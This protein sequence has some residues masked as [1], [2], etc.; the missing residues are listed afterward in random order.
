MKKLNELY[1]GYPNIEIK[2]IKTNSKEITEG[3]LFVCTMG[4]SVDRHDFVDDAISK[5]AVAIV[6]SKPINVSVPVIMVDNTNTELPILVNKFYD[7]PSSKMKMIG[8]TGTDGK[9]SITTIL[10]QM[11]NRV[12]VSG[13]IGT[14]GVKSPNYTDDSA[15]TTPDNNHIMKYLNNFVQDNCKYACLE[16]SSEGLIMR[17]VDNI[18]FDISIFTNLTHEHLNRH[19][20]MDN[21]CDAKALLFKQTNKDGISIINIDDEY[22]Q[23]M[24]EA[25][26]SKVSTY[27]IN[28]DANWMFYDVDIRSNGTTFK[29]K[30]KDKIYIV[31]SPL[32]GLF[33]VYNLTAALAAYD[34]CGFD[35][36][37]V[38]K[39]LSF[40]FIDG[41]MVHIDEGQNFQVIVDYAHTPNGLNSLF[42]FVNTLK[43]NR[44]I[45]VIGSGGERDVDKRPVMGEIVTKAADYVIFTMEDPRSED[46][47][48]IVDQM[49]STVRD[50]SNKY[51][52]IVDRSLAIKTAINMANEDD[53][54]FILGKGNETYQKVKGQVLY[55]NDIE[56]AIK[57]LKERRSN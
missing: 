7:Y 11:L 42:S 15:N 44:V 19:K 20:T 36:E 48:D 50:L 35:V 39:N 16:V 18:S 14:N 47:S 34:N 52:K 12:S 17:R 51:T 8:V 49:T 55:F 25:S 33:N 45:V 40:I 10:F 53:I 31:N 2:D 38:I 4:F 57:A 24:V 23:K 27:G 29:I 3:D 13:Y 43:K 26:V 6:A 41:R 56:E 28:K 46:P 54:I 37:E 30:N 32:C 5:G 1:E 21:Y 9:T 22:G